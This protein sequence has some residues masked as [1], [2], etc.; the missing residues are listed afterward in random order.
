MPQ[1]RSDFTQPKVQQIHVRSFKAVDGGPNAEA[2]LQQ[3][4][5]QSRATNENLEK[6][7]TSNSLRIEIY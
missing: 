4:T 1:I 3:S 6:I 2:L 7:P 5:G